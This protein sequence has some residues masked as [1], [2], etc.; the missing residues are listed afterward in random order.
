MLFSCCYT[1]F[2]ILSDYQTRFTLIH[3]YCMTKILQSVLIRSQDIASISYKGIRIFFIPFSFFI[4]IPH[5]FYSNVCPISIQSSILESNTIHR[6]SFVSLSICACHFA[7]IL[8]F[9]SRYL[10]LMKL[11]CGRVLHI[12]IKVT[13]CRSAYLTNDLSVQLIDVD[14]VHGAA[15]VIR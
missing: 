11:N 8:F 14:L 2:S 13:N 1:I 12:E 15:D 9:L 5:S 6:C 7:R 3:S 10:F 4:R